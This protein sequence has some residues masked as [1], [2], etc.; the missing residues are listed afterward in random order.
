MHELKIIQDIFPVITN[1]AAANDLKTISKVYLE[2]GELRQVIGEFLQFAFAAV[3]K[4]TIAAGAELVIKPILVTAK[5]NNCQQKVGVE[6]H[7][8][9]CPYCGSVG[10]DILTGKEIVLV[11]VEGERS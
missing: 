8:Y 9:I 7:S 5:C 11:S 3:A 10:L 6:K 1:V 4:E 2:V